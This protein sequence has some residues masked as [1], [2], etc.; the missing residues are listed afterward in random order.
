M[1]HENTSQSAC[2]TRRY[3]GSFTDNADTWFDTFKRA[4]QGAQTLTFKFL[5]QSF[6]RTFMFKKQS[7]RVVYY[8]K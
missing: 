8:M 6:I 2:K 4:V 5:N 7:G 3:S 1:K